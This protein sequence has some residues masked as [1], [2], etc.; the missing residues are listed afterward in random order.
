MFEALDLDDLM[1]EGVTD[2]D[3]AFELK[4]HETEVTDIDPKV[5][6][7]HVNFKFF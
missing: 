3:G 5:N 6:V 7:Y 1:G 2:E 4:G